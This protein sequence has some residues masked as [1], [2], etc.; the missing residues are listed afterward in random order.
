MPTQVARGVLVTRRKNKRGDFVPIHVYR[1]VKGGPKKTLAG[2]DPSTRAYQQSL[3]AAIGMVERWRASGSVERVGKLDDN[4]KA[5][6]RP[7][8]RPEYQRLAP[9]QSIESSTLLWLVEQ[10]EKSPQYLSCKLKTQKAHSRQLRDVCA[11]L[12][13]KNG[14]DAIVGDIRFSTITK[15]GVLRIRQRFA[16]TPGKADCVIVALR[17]MFYWA[18]EVGHFD[19][20]N[21]AAHLGKLR[22]DQ[23]GFKRCD[24]DQHAAIC[25][26]WRLGTPQRLAFDLALYTG[27]RV[28]DLV[29]LGPQHVK[30]GWITWTES[31]GKGS[32]A[33]KRK[34][35]HDKLQSLPVHPD[36]ARSI[37]A[38]PHGDFAFITQ[39]N[40][41][42]YKS[43]STLS[44]M[45][46]R[47]AKQAGVEG[48]GPHSFRKR[49]AT[50]IIDADGNETDAQQF[51]NHTTTAETRL[52]TKERDRRRR[53]ERA[54]SRIGRVA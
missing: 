38:T 40:G 18:I 11:L 6:T 13:P 33:I 32:Q 42:P 17:A 12:Y 10:F 51:L 50:A 54:I 24:D 37:A 35:K 30:R 48:V 46:R 20:V 45:M 34:L 53:A 4:G 29:G 5:I 7:S 8:E 36:L 22:D 28:S 39:G 49:G 16:A 15:E 2:V 19:H 21:P 23:K 3:Q 26:K 44:D 41:L 9:L 1:P 52:Y 14:P 25:R 43:D 31:K 27:A 47:W